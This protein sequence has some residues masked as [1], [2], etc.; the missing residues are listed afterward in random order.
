M[1]L[2]IFVGLESKEVEENNN[3]RVGIAEISSG[4]KLFLLKSL[5]V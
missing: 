5:I 2:D 3:T 1:D 4:S